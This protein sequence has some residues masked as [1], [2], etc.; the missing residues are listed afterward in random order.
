MSKDY[1]WIRKYKPKIL[2][3]V[4]GN[5]Q[6]KLKLKKFLDNYKKGQK[7]L[8]IHGAPGNGKTSAAYAAAEEMNLEVIEINASDTRNKKSITELLSSVLGQQSLFFSGKIILVD[9]IDGLSGTKDRG[10]VPA[11]LAA[12]KKSTFPVILTANDAYSKKLKA[13][14]KAA[15]TIEFL[16]LEINEITQILELIAKKENITCEKG[17]LKAIARRSNGDARAAI[18]DLQTLSNNNELSKADLEAL[19]DREHK[20][21]IKQALLKIF[22]TTS[23]DVALPSFDNVNENVDAIFLWIEENLSRVYKDPITRA[24]AYESLAE[25]DK[26]FG[27]IRRWQYYRFYVYI[28]N[29]LSAGIALAKDKKLEGTPIFRE[30]MKPLTIWMAN[31]KNAKRKAI[32][33]KISV[34]NHCSTKVAIQNTIPYL[35]PIFKK[36]QLEADKLANYFDFNSEETAWLAK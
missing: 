28:Y 1:A 29:F 33:E 6:A 25:A 14:R 24:K 15:E 11:L 16:P 4:V 36:N 23:A 17:S 30:S 19:G 26:F 34:K 22:K 2:G 35:K 9:E 21:N 7:P 32:A 8:L 3:D 27:R 31:M 13:I 18:N 12:I 10:G 5:S 20:E